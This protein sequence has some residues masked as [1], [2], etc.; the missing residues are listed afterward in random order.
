ML[1]ILALH[2]GIIV[3]SF[4]EFM[5]LEVT[6][7]SYEFVT[8]DLLLLLQNGGWLFL[9]WNFFIAVMRQLMQ[10]GVRASSKLKGLNGHRMLAR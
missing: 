8:R 2:A 5:L 7:L 9:Y 6:K 3:P 4:V 10:V 1:N